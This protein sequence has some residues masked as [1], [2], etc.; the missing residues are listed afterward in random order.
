MEMESTGKGGKT[1]ILAE[2]F[3]R[4]GERRSFSIQ[5]CGFRREMSVSAASN[6]KDRFSST[7]S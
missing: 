4:P 5:C 7:C 3:N 2:N 1:A 6:R